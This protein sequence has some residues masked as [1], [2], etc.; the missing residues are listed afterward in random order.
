MKYLILVFSS[1]KRKKLRTTLTLL[2][3]FVAFVLF[4]ALCVIQEAFLGGVKLAGV[5]RLVVRHKVSIIQSFPQSYETRV[6]AM[7]GVNA[8]A[9]QSWFGGVYQNPK[10]F[11]ATIA[12]EPESFL[13]V[14]TE[15]VLPPEQMEAWKQKRN[16]VIVGASSA[17]RFAWKVGD[18]VPFTSPIWGAPQ[19]GEHW[20]FEVVG[21][22][23]GAKKSTD[24]S[25]L[26]LRYDYFDEG[27]TRLKGEIGWM[28]VRVADPSQAGAIAKQIDEEFANS[29]YETKTEPEGAFAA[30]FAQQIGDIGTIV[31]GVIS[32]VFFT[33]LLVAGNTMSQSVRERTEELG[34]LKAMGFPNGLILWLV[35]AESCFLALIA[36]LAGLGLVWLITQGENPVPQLIQIF[37]FPTRDVILGAAMALLLG[38]MAGILPAWQAMRLPIAT[39]LRRG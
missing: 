26:Y 34:V 4:G 25:T 1:L 31:M 12:V 38:V 11:I 29:A 16:G 27:R 5:D 35:L 30:S 10:N 15:F 23:T 22:Y 8:V 3:I 21:I 33:I 36:G 28:T 37:N 14:Y 6:R 20:D 24:T 19:G 18:I 39:A 32:A 17:E 2:S 13:D 7:P 9:A